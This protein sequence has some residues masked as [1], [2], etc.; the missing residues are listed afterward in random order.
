MRAR[1]SRR[2]SDGKRLELLPVLAAVPP[3]F[4]KPKPAA[5]E[6]QLGGDRGPIQCYKCK[7]FGH[8]AANCPNKG[9]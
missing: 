7:E 1:G 3:G 4:E 2:D 8:V 6:G 9:G 5:G